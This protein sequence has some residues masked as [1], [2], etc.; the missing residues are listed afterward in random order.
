MEWWKDAIV[1]KIAVELKKKKEARLAREAAATA[2]EKR[3]KIAE[4]SSSKW[5]LDEVI[6]L[7][8]D[9]EEVL[10]Q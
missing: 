2:A 8:D 10:A 9:E 4:V 5:T 3:W 6:K 7:D 1:E